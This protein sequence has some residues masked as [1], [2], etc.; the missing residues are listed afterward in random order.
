MKLISAC[1]R[2]RVLPAAQS[3][4]GDL[5]TLRLDTPLVRRPGAKQSRKSHRIFNSQSEN[6]DTSANHFSKNKTGPD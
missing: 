1:A 2:P 6:L 3:F 4:T 5:L